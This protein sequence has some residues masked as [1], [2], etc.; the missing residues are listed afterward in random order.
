[1]EEIKNAIKDDITSRIQILFF[2]MRRID[3]TDLCLDLM[4]QVS[5]FGLLFIGILF[6]LPD[7]ILKMGL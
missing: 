1:M 6:I 5:S 3:Y 2:F 7:N 4:Q